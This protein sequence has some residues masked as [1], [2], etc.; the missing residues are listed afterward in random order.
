MKSRVSAALLVLLATGCSGGSA[1]HDGSADADKL[2][3]AMAEHDQ[4]QQRFAAV[5]AAD[6]AKC[7][8]RAGD[9]LIGA[10]E[11]RDMVIEK[12]NLNECRNASAQREL[13]CMT[14]TLRSRGGIRELADHYGFEN[15]CTQQLLTCTAQ[16]ADENA[17][18]AR[19]ARF[20]L[21]KREIET[22][23]QGIGA[24]NEAEVARTKVRYVRSTLPTKAAELCP[25]PGSPKTCDEQ[26]KEELKQFEA[27]LRSD[28]YD[29]KLATSLYE[30]SKKTEASCSAPELECLMSGIQ[31]YGALPETRKWLDR[32]LRALEERQHLAVNAPFE[33]ESTCIAETASK[34]EPR[35]QA[36]HQIYSKQPVL[37]F[38]SQLERTYLAMHEEQVRCLRTNGKV[39]DPANR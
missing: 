36:A 18:A 1:R 2:Q 17:A 3:S 30:T 19:V 5:P 12:R 33:L 25:E 29:A 24:W 14:R 8:T 13:Q 26:A 16:V 9:C 15:W 39:A 35:I 10:S 23:P 20:E 34:H 32:N 21:R 6:R 27:A 22:S 38:R 28:D 7:E 31:A 37:F 11:R 4:L